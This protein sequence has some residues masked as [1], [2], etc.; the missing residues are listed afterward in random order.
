MRGFHWFRVER[1]Y[2]QLKDENLDQK[3]SSANKQAAVDGDRNSLIQLTLTQ[4]K[5]RKWLIRSKA[6]L[7]PISKQE[8]DLMGT[9]VNEISGESETGILQSVPRRFPFQEIQWGF[10]TAKSLLLLSSYKDEVLGMSVIALVP[11][12]KAL[13]SLFK[14]Q[15]N[16]QNK[17]QIFITKGAV[18]ETVTL[19]TIRSMNECDYRIS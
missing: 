18:T 4:L 10:V 2:P 16:V 3:F 1:V 9:K 8:W 14:K 7:T 6:C 12:G 19:K 5:Q 17:T 15:P 13:I 11:Q